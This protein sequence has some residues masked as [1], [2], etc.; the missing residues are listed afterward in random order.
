[1]RIEDI[2]NITDGEL[3]NEG[4]IKD[5][6]AFSDEVKKVKREYLFV[7]NNIDDI[8]EAINQGAY[9]ILF[10]K[11]IDIIDEEIAWIRV[12]DLNEAFLKLLKYK[13]L[14]KTLYYSDELTL[15]II[16]SIN[17][18]KRLAIIDKVNFEYLN[19]DYI[20]ITSQE[21]VKNIAIEKQQ[22]TKEIN[23][24]PF[25]VTPFIME[26]YFKNQ[27]Y[28]LVFPI[29]YLRQ[30]EIALSFFEKL[31][32]SY[33]LKDIKI[34]RFIPQFINSRYEKVP[35]GRTEKVVIQGIKKDKYF[36]NELN[37]IFKKLKYANV[38]FYDN[39]NI[40]NF[41]KDKFNFA[42]LIDCEIELKEKEVVENNL[43]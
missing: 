1:M 36:I 33:Y 26:F 13:L 8:K 38:K 27:K 34:N 17:R 6:L 11:N 22:L 9:A 39:T 37:Y 16:S 7:S 10:S 20:Y 2:V 40:D 21:K 19:D 3:I 43:F 31:D 23:I 28:S 24:T 5:I 12:E 4:Y 35:F 25:Y 18:D 15:Q 41:Y 14:D 30:L 32:L 29:L 42:V